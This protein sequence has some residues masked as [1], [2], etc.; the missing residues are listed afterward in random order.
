MCIQPCG[1][2]F[3]A[4]CTEKI[5]NRCFACNGTVTAKMKMYLLGKDDGDDDE[6]VP[7][8]AGGEVQP[9]NDRN[10]PTRNAGIGLVGQLMGLG[11]RI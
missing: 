5:T 8:T 4:S 3:C 7:D 9:A 11:Q 6:A 1:H 2:T 10:Y